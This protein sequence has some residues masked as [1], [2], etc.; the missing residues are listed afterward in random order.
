MKGQV[1]TAFYLIIDHC[2]RDHIIK[3]T[4][5]EEFRVL[6]TKRELDAT[7]LDAFI[8][9]PY[10]IC[11]IK[12]LDVSYLWNKIWRPAF[13]SKTMSK[14]DFAEIMRFIGFDKKSE[15]S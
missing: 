15:R 12:N 8:A 11:Y 1:K 3:R 9:L 14:N 10:A 7:K 6:G 4:E 13:F 5:E 2:T